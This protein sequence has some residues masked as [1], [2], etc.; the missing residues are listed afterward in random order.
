MSPCEEFVSYRCFLHILGFA[1]QSSL[2]LLIC[3]LQHES[4]MLLLCETV[5][6]CKPYQGL[7]WVEHSVFV[8]ALTKPF[9]VEIVWVHLWFLLSIGVIFVVAVSSSNKPS[10]DWLV[11]N[12]SYLSVW[13]FLWLDVPVSFFLILILDMCSMLC[14]Y[15][16][17]LTGQRGPKGWLAFLVSSVSILSVVILAPFKFQG[18]SVWFRW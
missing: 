9:L 2:S 10:V 6:F 12:S 4:P 3:P 7:L 5:L 17:R 11:W 8:M 1:Q 16:C 14:T 18:N 13:C 15:R